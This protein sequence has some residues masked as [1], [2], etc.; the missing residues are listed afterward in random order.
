MTRTD[1]H[2]DIWFQ[3]L[4]ASQLASS[5]NEHP[6]AKVLPVDILDAMASH[7]I[8][9]AEGHDASLAYIDELSREPS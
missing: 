5:L 9:F 8:C 6:R 3:K 7:G 4:S 2:E 1:S